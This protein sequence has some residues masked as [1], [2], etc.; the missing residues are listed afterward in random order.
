MTKAQALSPRLPYAVEEGSDPD[1][2]VEEHGLDV[3]LLQVIQELGE[4]GHGLERNQVVGVVFVVHAVDHGRQQLGP[5]L[6]YLQ[7]QR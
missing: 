4:T 7:G 2:D 5:V 1:G 6:P 3:S